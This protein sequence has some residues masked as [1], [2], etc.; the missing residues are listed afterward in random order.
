MTV[1]KA[2]GQS[3]SVVLCIALKEVSILHQTAT[4]STIRDKRITDIRFETKRLTE[5]NFDNFGT[6]SIQKNGCQ[7][8]ILTRR[9]K[10]FKWQVTV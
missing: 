6:F 5:K 4:I 8:I 3:L 1:N 7:V 2:F 9:S 10:Q